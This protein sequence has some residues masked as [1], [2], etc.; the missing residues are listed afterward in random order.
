VI[1]KISYNIV[2]N[3]FRYLVSKDLGIDAV[4]QIN[5]RHKYDYIEDMTVPMLHDW[6]VSLEILHGDD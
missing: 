3:F 2:P 6:Q 1:L 5:E 4:H